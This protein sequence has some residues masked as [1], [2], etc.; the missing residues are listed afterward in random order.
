MKIAQAAKRALIICVLTVVFS[1]AVFAAN[2]YS[3]NVYAAGSKAYSKLTTDSAVYGYVYIEVQDKD[4]NV[5]V[6]NENYGNTTKLVT[7]VDYSSYPAHNHARG[8]FHATID[9]TYKSSE[10]YCNT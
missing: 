9:G 5:L 3:H 10:K 7:S 1:I 2:S 8:V 4:D 6:N